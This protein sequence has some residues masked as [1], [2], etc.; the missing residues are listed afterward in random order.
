MGE[1]FKR[2]LKKEKEAWIA[3]EKV[4]K[5]K[6]EED[7]INE[8]RKGTVM[9]LE[10]TIIELVEKHKRALREAREQ[11]QTQEAER[12]EGVIEEYEKR[13]KVM[14]EK[15]VREKDEALDMERSKLQSKLH[16]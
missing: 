5:E 11:A 13:L 6:W 2:E 14:R 3:S 9:K 12:V 8:I 1:R 7:K 15:L 16:E 10:P 4:R